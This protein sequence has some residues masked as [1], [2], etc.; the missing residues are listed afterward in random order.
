MIFRLLLFFSLLVFMPQNFAGTHFNGLNSGSSDD[1]PEGK[2]WSEW[3]EKPGD[4]V[5]ELALKGYRELN[6][7][8]VLSKPEV[9]TIID[10]SLPS[11][12]ER[13]W[14]VD[15]KNREILHTSLVAHGRNSGERFAEYFS[16]VSGSYT[17]S[18]GFYVTGE[19]YHGKHG[20]SLYLDGMEPGINDAARDRAIVMHSADY[21]TRDFAETHGRL[22][23]SL[24]CPSIPPDDHEEIIEMLAGGTC[25]FIYA[26]NEDYLSKSAL[27]S[28]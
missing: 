10:F 23:R 6:H 11:E 1:F 18:L 5:F 12:Q 17:S 3:M 27:A 21:A 13:M 24:G 25:L 7:S 20:L 16:N 2:W 28:L 26:P 4:V 15:L 14:I 19:T 22:G 8:G 9:I